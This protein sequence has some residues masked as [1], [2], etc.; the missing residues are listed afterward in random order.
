MD[1]D[2]E[3]R[4]SGGGEGARPPELSL[5]LLSPPKPMP[6]PLPVIFDV[7]GGAGGSWTIKH[8]VA[9]LRISVQLFAPIDVH[10]PPL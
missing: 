4:G 1:Q 7:A 9:R 6:P 8:S 3:G 10:V 2:V 5:P